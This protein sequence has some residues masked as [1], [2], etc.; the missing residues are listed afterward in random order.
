MNLLELLT[1]KK[2][3]ISDE[4]YKKYAK[5]Y[6]LTEPTDNNFDE[7]VN[8]IYNLI[9]NENKDDIEL[10]AKESDCT[11]EE[12]IMKIRYL[13]NKR[14]IGD[15]Y[16]DVANKI[17]RKCSETDQQLLK[18][19]SK[20]IYNQHLQID[21]IA[22]R[23]TRTTLENLEETKNNIY[24]DISYLYKKGLLNGIKLNNVDKSIAYYTIDKKNP[25]MELKTLNCPN[26]G[27]INELNKHS[28]VKCDYCGTIIE[29]INVN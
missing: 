21:E 18:K 28:K 9:I 26:C 19:Y 1:T 22:L 5:Y 13:K 24:N 23:D 3:N 14:L 4:S 11:L 7:K 25:S 27:A 29:D 17:I 12:C 10:I 20:Y 8:K 16:I 6:D 2:I 15:Y